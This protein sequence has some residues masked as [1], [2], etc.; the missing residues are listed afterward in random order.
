MS[1]ERRP[2]LDPLEALHSD[3]SC[4]FRIQ[5]DD[6]I[7]NQSYRQLVSRSADAIREP[8]DPISH[9]P[10]VLRAMC[11]AHCNFSFAIFRAM[12]VE[13][14]CDPRNGEP[15]DCNH[16]LCVRDAQSRRLF[17]GLVGTL[18]NFGSMG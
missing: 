7:L 14:I 10:S 16:C 17:D 18:A 4:V 8:S 9:W 6:A 13:P 12:S 15:V 2:L 11:P 3:R 1:A 5:H